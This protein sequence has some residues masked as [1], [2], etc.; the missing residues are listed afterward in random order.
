MPEASGE[1]Q[2]PAEIEH[3]DEVMRRRGQALE[4]YLNTP[5][6]EGGPGPATDDET[7]RPS[8]FKG[9]P[10]NKIEPEKVE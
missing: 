7:A 10:G 2:V 9:V 1:Q 6:A 8:P 4:A 3:G 5:E